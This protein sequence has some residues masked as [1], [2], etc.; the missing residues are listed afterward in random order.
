VRVLSIFAMSRAVMVVVS[1]AAGGIIGYQLGWRCLFRIQAVWTAITFIGVLLLLPKSEQRRAAKDRKSVPKERQ[2]PSE[3]DE[4]GDDEDEEDETDFSA[5]PRLP[6]RDYRSSDSSASSASKLYS[7]LF[8]GLTVAHALTMAASFT[9]LLSLPFT[10]RNYY[11]NSPQGHN[12]ARSKGSSSSSSSS[13]SSIPHID[14]HS[15]DAVLVGPLM[16]VVPFL[17]LVIAALTAPWLDYVA[18]SRAMRLGACSLGA[19]AVL[20]LCA[21][22]FRWY[23]HGRWWVTLLCCSCFVAPGFT[24]RPS[25]ITLLLHP[26]DNPQHKRKRKRHWK[27]N[28][29]RVEGRQEWKA[30]GYDDGLDI[31]TG[32]R[33]YADDDEDEESAVLSNSGALHSDDPLEEFSKEFASKVR[34]VGRPGFYCNYT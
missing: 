6:S 29:R 25:F 21:G 12:H 22:Y 32:S 3:E 28:R 31:Y 33:T 2:A 18:P 14:M 24:T 8:V 15:F 16:A 7:T 9:M 19:S 26:F 13:S 4:D 17:G 20:L 23:A 11:S 30:S 10:L 1:P 27:R 34:G 5:S